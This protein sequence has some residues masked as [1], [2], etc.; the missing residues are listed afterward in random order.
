MKKRFWIQLRDERSIL[1]HMK[2]ISR[3]VLLG[4]I[5]AVMAVAPLSRA[6]T[7]KPVVAAH[8]WVY[9]ATQPSYDIYPILDGIFADMSWAGIEAIELMHTALESDG[10]VAR[11]SELSEKY[12]LP[13]IG[14]SYSASMFD[15]SQQASILEYAE[16]MIGRLAQLGGRTLGTSV[17]DA[18][19]KKTATELDAQGELVTKLM[20]LCA[21]RKVV[22]N[23]HNHIYEAQDGEY[24]LR[25]TLA[26][27][28]GV[29]LGPDLDWLKGAGLDPADFITRYGGRIVYA[30]LRDRKADGVWSEAMGEG[31]IDYRAIAAA[32][33][34]AGFQGDVAIELAHPSGF[35]PTRPLRESL[36]ISRE[37]VRRTLGW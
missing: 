13:V 16:K 18:R 27:V 11:I 37:F 34:S 28:A 10:A 5:P 20:A 24:D 15:R 22:L 1:G 17:G 7:H 2:N 12:K 21:S 35:K 4:S 32:F 14:S 30:H 26:R 8:P 19:R 23:L 6:N 9:A 25:G 36:K 31:A 29:K 33:R 3:R